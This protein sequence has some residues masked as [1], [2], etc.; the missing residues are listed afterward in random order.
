M[1]KYVK[2]KD[3]VVVR[4]RDNRSEVLYF[5]FKIK[6]LFNDDNS[7]VTYIMNVFMMREGVLVP[8]EKEYADISPIQAV[9]R[10]S[11][12]LSH[13]GDKTMEFLL[14][15]EMTILQQEM[16]NNSDQYWK[17]TSDKTEIVEI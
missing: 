13:W 10:L 1:A 8:A 4:T 9:Y 7:T 15:N 16:S 2:S 14:E 12:W 3:P 17:L 11:T 5:N 6:H